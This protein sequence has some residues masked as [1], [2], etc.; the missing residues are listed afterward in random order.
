MLFMYVTGWRKSAVA[1]LEWD[2]DARNG[3]VVLRGMKSKN[4]L[5]YFVPE[6]GEIHTIIERRRVARKVE[7]NGTVIVSNLVLHD[8]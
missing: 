5:P 7:M 1:S 6:T 2:P 3:C 4:G 8:G